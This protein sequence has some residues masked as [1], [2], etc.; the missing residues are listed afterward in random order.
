MAS[1]LERSDVGPAARRR[2]GP[3]HTSRRTPPPVVEALQPLALGGAGPAPALLDF[4]RRARGRAG[5]LVG[6]HG[7]DEIEQVLAQPLGQRRLREAGEARLSRAQLVHAREVEQ[8]L[9][10]G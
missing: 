3:Y 4:L 1:L 2:R 8:E 5:L 10:G 9:V 6:C 7:A